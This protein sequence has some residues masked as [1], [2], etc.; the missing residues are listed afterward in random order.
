MKEIPILGVVIG[1]RQ[2]KS[3]QG[4]ED[5]NKGQRS[6]KLPGICKLLQE[7]YTKLQ[8]PGKINTKTDILS[9]N[10]Q[11]DIQDNNRDVQLLKKEL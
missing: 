9:R 7:I 2:D 11:V 3:G 10:D 4:I 8:S 1:K 6:R 5:T